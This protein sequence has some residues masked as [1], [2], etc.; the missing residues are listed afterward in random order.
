VPALASRRGSPHRKVRFILGP[1]PNWPAG[2][3]AAPL[4]VCRRPSPG[5]TPRARAAPNLAPASAPGTLATPSPAAPPSHS[6]PVSHIQALPR[7]HPHPAL[8]RDP[9]ALRE[10]NRP[11]ATHRPGCE[12]C[13]LKQQFFFGVGIASLV[14]LAGYGTQGSKGN[15]QYPEGAGDSP[16]MPSTTAAGNCPFLP[17]CFISCDSYAGVKI[18]D[19]ADR[20]IKS[21]VLWPYGAKAHFVANFVITPDGDS[22]N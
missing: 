7:G 6:C 16:S 21:L 20:F 12:G 9:G 4:V 5:A 14:T 10:F 22:E 15:P 8:G 17:Y 18:I 11:L 1:E 3:G 2:S 19:R 13:A